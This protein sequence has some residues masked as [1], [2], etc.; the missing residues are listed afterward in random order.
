MTVKAGTVVPLEGTW[1][2]IEGSKKFSVSDIVVP[3]EGTWIEITT[4]KSGRG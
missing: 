2:D 4:A 3:L 1:I